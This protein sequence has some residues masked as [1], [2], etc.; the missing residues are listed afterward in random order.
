MKAKEYAEKY[1]IAK[2]KTECLSEI[3]TSF[4]REF[5]D[6]VKSRNARRDSAIF[7]IL[8]ELDQKWNAF[9]K[10][11]EYKLDPDGFE[12]LINKLFPDVFVKWKSDTNRRLQLKHG[13]SAYEKFCRLD[14][15]LLK[16]KV[17]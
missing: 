14:L 16:E 5:I 12:Y 11:V 6:L 4:Y 13:E 1:N 8:D 15:P 2:D 10:R 9:V 3:L 17:K 7:G